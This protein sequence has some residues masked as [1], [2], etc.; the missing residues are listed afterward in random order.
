MLTNNMWGGDRGWETGRKGAA[1]VWEAGDEGAGSRIP[2]VA[3]SRRK[4][5]NYA[6]LPKILQKQKCKE[7]GA[8]KYRART[9]IKGYGKRE[10]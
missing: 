7:A 2:K 5:E 9:G 8:N 3:G 1:G 6:T 4:K 10:V